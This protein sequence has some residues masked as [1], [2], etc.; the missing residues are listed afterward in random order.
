M[1]YALDARPDISVLR[2]NNFVAPNAA[3]I[4][5]VVLERGAS[6]WWGV[7]I[8]DNDVITSARTS[9]SRTARSSTPMAASRASCTGT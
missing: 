9:T 2:G 3:V 4:G 6:V 7:T 1:I 8:R 5:S